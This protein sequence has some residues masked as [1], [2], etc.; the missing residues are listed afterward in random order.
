[1]LYNPTKVN[2]EI[3]D[4]HQ[5][6]DGDEEPQWYVRI[7]NGVEAM[8]QKGSV[9]WRN[10]GAS[11]TPVFGKRERTGSGSR[12]GDDAPDD[13]G[14][15]ET[16]KPRASTRENRTEDHPTNVEQV[17]NQDCIS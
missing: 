13:C 11:F 15:V 14:D 8:E 10:A 5:Y 3:E 1:M 6:R 4:T 7:D 12:L 9:E 17:G 2:S 16:G